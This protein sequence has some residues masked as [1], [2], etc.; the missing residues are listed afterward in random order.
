MGN[1]QHHFIIYKN[2]GRRKV[3]SMSKNEC[4]NNQMFLGFGPFASC[5]NSITFQHPCTHT[6][7][8]KNRFGH[9]YMSK[10]STFIIFITFYHKQGTRATQIES[11]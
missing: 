2:T 11:F 1:K 3:L 8:Q 9:R 10:P 5:M 4:I 7:K 6:H